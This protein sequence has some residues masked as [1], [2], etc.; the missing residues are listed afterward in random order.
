MDDNEWA[1]R[2]SE[3][4]KGI[5]A[6][7]VMP[8]HDFITNPLTQTASVRWVHEILDKQYFFCLLCNEKVGPDYRGPG[9][10]TLLQAGDGG[11]IG[12]ISTICADCVSEHTSEQVFA[13]AFKI[14]TEALGMDDA[15]MIDVH[16]S[17]GHA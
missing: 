9:A 17:T 2:M 3:E 7:A 13:R 1:D 8:L 15:R 10:V 14:T 6:F 4:A 12:S 5:Y 16:A 11:T